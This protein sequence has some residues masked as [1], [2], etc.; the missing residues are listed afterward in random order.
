MDTHLGK[1]A[2]ASV[3][4]GLFAAIPPPWGQAV[5]LSERHPAEPDPLRPIRRGNKILGLSD[6]LSTVKSMGAVQ[7]RCCANSD[8]TLL[9]S[10]L[11]LQR[12]MK[13]V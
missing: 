11:G 13:I 1:V 8:S 2:Q 10:K 9:A 5:E 4:Y 7:P 6:D 12:R 3:A